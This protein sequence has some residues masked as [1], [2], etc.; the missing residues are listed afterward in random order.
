MGGF[1]I[2]LFKRLTPH[3]KE[4][5]HEGNGDNLA[6]QLQGFIADFV[7]GVVPNNLKCYKHESRARSKGGPDKAGRYDGSVPERAA[8][9]ADIQKC[10]Y[11]MNADGPR[12]SRRSGS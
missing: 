3:H 8:R 1:C 2:K 6:E 5:D 7:F 4:I 11:G 10:S 9:E 12:K